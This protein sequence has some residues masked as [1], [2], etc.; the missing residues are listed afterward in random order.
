MRFKSLLSKNSFI[1][2]TLKAAFSKYFAGAFLFG[3]AL[4]SYVSLNQEYRTFIQVPLQISLPASRAFESAPP[5]NLTVA[6]KGSGWQI[7]NLFFSS[8]ALCQIDLTKSDI[9][10]TKYEITRDNIMKGIQSLNFVQ[11]TD[12]IP[13]YLKINTGAVGEY[14]VP[15]EPQIFITPKAGYT[16]VGDYQIKPDLVILRGIDGIARKITKWASKPYFFEN[17]TEPINTQI[18]LSDSL[19]G[20]IGLNTNTIKLFADIQQIAEITMPDIPVRIIGGNLPQAHFV[21]PNIVSVTVQGGIKCI[22]E[23]SQEQITVNL[24]LVQILN[25]STGIIIPTVSVPKNIHILK[26]NP[27]YLFHK[28]R[29]K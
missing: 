29:I 8:S 26:V 12:I 2:R 1:R 16:V 7:F 4:W 11:A 25:D 27:P 21:E 5:E 22:K 23:L 19:K 9:N 10:N 17:S 3:T 20:I 14:S 13:E 18:M 24:N 6:I 15:I 28:I